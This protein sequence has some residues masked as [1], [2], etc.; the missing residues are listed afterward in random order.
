MLPVLG[1]RNEKFSLTTTL[2]TKLLTNPLAQSRSTADAG[3]QSPASGPSSTQADCRWHGSGQW[4]RRGRDQRS[5]RAASF[6]KRISTRNRFLDGSADC[7]RA[8]YASLGDWQRTFPA[9]HG[10]VRTP[11]AA[12][13]PR[14]RIAARLTHRSGDADGRFADERCGCSLGDR[15]GKEI[16]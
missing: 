1:L 4:T 14:S 2:T 12:F 10:S 6:V 16:A 7:N 11:P 3:D 13:S 15:G 5:N 9:V 8:T